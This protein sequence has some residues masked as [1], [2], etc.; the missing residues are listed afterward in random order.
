MCI[1]IVCIELSQKK[2]LFLTTSMFFILGLPSNLPSYL[3]LFIARAFPGSLSSNVQLYTIKAVLNYTVGI[4]NMLIKHPS[5][6]AKLQR[7][8]TKYKRKLTCLSSLRVFCSLVFWQLFSH[9][10]LSAQSMTFPCMS[11]EAM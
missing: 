11:P 3:K 4:I 9:L 1:S 5:L 6:L 8:I 7:T 2:E 10:L